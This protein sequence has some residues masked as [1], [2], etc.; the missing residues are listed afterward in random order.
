MVRN[1]LMQS[2]IAHLCLG[3][4]LSFDHQQLGSDRALW[5]LYQNRWPIGLYQ[6]QHLDSYEF[7]CREVLDTTVP[8]GL[9]GTSDFVSLVV[10]DTH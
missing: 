9:V 8:L 4:F 1:E 7:A 6:F 2:S 3:M 5:I 10:L